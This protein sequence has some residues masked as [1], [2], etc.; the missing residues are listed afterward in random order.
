MSITRPTLSP[1][2][3]RVAI[4]LLSFSKA[5][6][7]I[8][9][10]IAVTFGG[11]AGSML[12]EDHALATLPIMLSL[13]GAGICTV[14]AS[15]LM[16][17]IGR[18]A[19]FV[20]GAAAGV[21]GA[22]LACGALRAGSF[23]ELCAGFVLLGVYQAFSQYY[24]FA[25]TDRIP[26]DQASGAVALVMAGGVVAAL[27][28]SAVARWS[29]GL[30][31]GLPLEGPFAVLA[32]LLAANALAFIP[33]GGRDPRATPRPGDAA[34]RSTAILADPAFLKATF[35]TA[36]SFLIMSCV[37]TAAPLAI[38]G[39]GL[40]TVA[41]AQAI[42]WHLVGMF[43]P[44]FLL[45]LKLFRRSPGVTIGVGCA[46]S[47]LFGAEHRGTRQRPAAGSLHDRHGAARHRLELPLCRFHGAAGERPRRGG[48]GQG[49]RA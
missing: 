47:A 9:T 28:S 22:V 45:Q 12:A 15:L 49:A 35:F 33:L 1:S 32:V 27:A 48:P 20:L 31:S 18:R 25:V 29:Q 16:G 2:A 17:R 3:R 24:R 46:A 8:A 30:F 6:Q 38:V 36:S 41:A 37:M 13:L 42:Q 11:I 14:P 19:G 26:A 39:C 7:V 43:G 40:S 10:S 5:V 44:S 4:G 21:A 34:R 23:T